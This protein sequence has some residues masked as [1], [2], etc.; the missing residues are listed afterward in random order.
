MRGKCLH[1]HYIA[2][3]NEKGNWSSILMDFTRSRSHMFASTDDNS[4]RSSSWPTHTNR[5]SRVESHRARLAW[6]TRPQCVR[7]FCHACIR[8]ACVHIIYVVVVFVG[9]PKF[10]V[11]GYHTVDGAWRF[12]ASR[13]PIR[14]SR[15]PAPIYLDR[16]TVMWRQISV[17]TRKSLCKCKLR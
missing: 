10:I 4:R 5:T 16:F 15:M 2:Q 9:L 13:R 12:S 11:R 8:P 3:R 6:L 7:L 14:V 17:I 1:H